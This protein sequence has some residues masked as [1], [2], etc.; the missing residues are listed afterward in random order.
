MSPE[1]RHRK[2]LSGVGLCPII[3]DENSQGSA[4]RS[5]NDSNVQKACLEYKST[6]KKYKIDARV[7]KGS[8]LNRLTKSYDYNSF[9]KFVVVFWAEE[10]STTIG[11]DNMFSNSLTAFAPMEKTKK[12]WKWSVSSQPIL[13]LNA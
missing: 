7:I 5:R 8:E 4:S 12:G 13:L 11:M 10:K 1:P 3:I 2:N 9:S 6:G